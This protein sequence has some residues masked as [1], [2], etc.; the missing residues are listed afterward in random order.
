MQKTLLAA[1]CQGSARRLPDNIHVDAKLRRDVQIIR[2]CM[3]FQSIT[4]SYP[5]LAKLVRDL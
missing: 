1:V 4:Q 5:L 2:A 3:A